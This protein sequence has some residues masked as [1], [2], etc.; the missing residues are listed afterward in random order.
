MCHPAFLILMY[1]ILDYLILKSLQNSAFVEHLANDWFL[2]WLLVCGRNVSLFKYLLITLGSR[3]QIVRT[4]V[5]FLKYPLEFPNTTRRLEYRLKG[6]GEQ[7]GLELRPPS[8]AAKLN[9]N[10]SPLIP[11]SNLLETWFLILKILQNSAF[12]ELL[13]NDWFLAWLLGCGGT[14]PSS[15]TY[16]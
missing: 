6:A 3:I 10:V 11:Y 9:S 15:N 5:I 8:L 14:F 2:S 13:A 7:R 12:V 1:L 4:F 16:W